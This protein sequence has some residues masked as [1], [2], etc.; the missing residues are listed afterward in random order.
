MRCVAR[1]GSV[2]WAAENRHPCFA[3]DPVPTEVGSSFRQSALHCLSKS[4]LQHLVQGSTRPLQ[5]RGELGDLVRDANGEAAKLPNLRRQSRLCDVD[6]R[7]LSDNSDQ[8]SVGFH[9]CLPW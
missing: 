1:R 2:D 6:S 5:D 3:T 4:H 9:I 7:R 8:L